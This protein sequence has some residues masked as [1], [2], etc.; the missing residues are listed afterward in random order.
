[1]PPATIQPVAPDDVAEAL[2]DVAA[3]PPRNG[4]VALA[5]D[6]AIGLDEFVRL[7]LAAEEDPAPDLRQLSAV[8]RKGVQAEPSWGSWLTTLPKPVG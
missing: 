4:I 7:I 5:G 3:G 8:P 2:A 6:E 1:V